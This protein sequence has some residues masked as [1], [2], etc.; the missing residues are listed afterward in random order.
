M[1]GTST[2]MH[3]SIHIPTQSILPQLTIEFNVSQANREQE[4]VE[5]I[6]ARVLHIQLAMGNEMSGSKC[7]GQLCIFGDRVGLP[8]SDITLVP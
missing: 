6:E 3:T 2:G 5:R 4:K 1:D 8:F 7:M